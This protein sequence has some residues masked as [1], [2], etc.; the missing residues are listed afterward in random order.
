[1][2][3]LRVESNLIREWT[4]KHANP[5]ALENGKIQKLTEMGFTKEQ[6]RA[7]LV[8]VGW[9]EEAAINKLLGA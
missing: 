9:E 3:P 5:L 8:S 2:F 6:A 1:V 7:A 4:D